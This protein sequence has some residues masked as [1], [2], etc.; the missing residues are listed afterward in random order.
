MFRNETFRG[1]KPNFTTTLD[2]NALPLPFAQATAGSEQADI[3]HL[4][5]LFIRYGKL[6][7]F[8]ITLTYLVSALNQHSGEP[9][10]RGLTGTRNQ[11][12]GQ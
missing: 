2:E 4:S 9:L 12:V 6:N 5:Q 8:T 10:W 11:H 3:G 1:A 7:L